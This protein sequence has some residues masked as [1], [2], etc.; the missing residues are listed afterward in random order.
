MDAA[1]GLGLAIAGS[2][3]LSAA[4]VGI[5]ELYRKAVKKIDKGGER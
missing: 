5:G 2:A 4:L 3:A 1:Q